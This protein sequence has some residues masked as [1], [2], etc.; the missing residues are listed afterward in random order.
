MGLVTY[1]TVGLKEHP[2]ALEGWIEAYS[3]IKPP[4]PTGAIRA[5]DSYHSPRGDAAELAEQQAIWDRTLGPLPH[6]TTDQIA[7]YWALI[8]VSESDEVST[9]KDTQAQAEQDFRKIALA[10]FEAGN[11]NPPP[12]PQGILGVISAATQAATESALFTVEESV[13]AAG[14]FTAEGFGPPVAQL[15]QIGQDKILSD[16]AN[17]AWVLSQLHE[18]IRAQTVGAVQEAGLAVTEQAEAARRE[19]VYREWQELKKSGIQKVGDWIAKNALTVLA[20]VGAVVGGVLTGGALAIAAG[21]AAA[22]GKA[23]QAKVGA[24]ARDKVQETNQ[25]AQAEKTQ[26]LYAYQRQCYDALHEARPLAEAYNEQQRVIWVTAWIAAH[27][28]ST[29]PQANP[30]IT[31]PG[32]ATVPGHV[33]YH[34]PIGVLQGAELEVSSLLNRAEKALGAIR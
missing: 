25:Q 3:T 30:K 27:G 11:A 31:E 13:I 24:D 21:C 20:V 32:P 34:E 8:E 28:G 4:R 12:V 2:W 14:A 18:D 19:F 26:A 29:I 7:T 16:Q 10:G 33:T 22:V 6:P 1:E 5:H 15:G 23:V 17:Q 9:D